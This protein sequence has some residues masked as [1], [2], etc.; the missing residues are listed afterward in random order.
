MATTSLVLPTVAPPRG[1]AARAGGKGSGARRQT[2]L[3]SVR[4]CK[5]PEVV[6]VGRRTSGA[7]GG[8]AGVATS[9]LPPANEVAG[10][11]IGVSA[12]SPS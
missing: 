7:R 12:A 1:A 2:T 3:A 10:F 4:R 8:K 11:V 5:T 9:A 6:R